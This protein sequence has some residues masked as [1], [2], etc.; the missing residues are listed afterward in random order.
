[1]IR[2]NFSYGNHSEHE[3]VIDHIRKISNTLGKY[4][5]I[6]QEISGSKV[7]IGYLETPV[8]MKEDFVFTFTANEEIKGEHIIP[9]NT[10]GLPKRVKPGEL[11]Y[12]NEGQIK[13]KVIRTSL[14]EIVCKVIKGGRITSYKT[15]NLPMSKLSLPVLTDKD[16]EDILFGINKG[17][18]MLSVSCVRNAWDIHTIKKFLEKHGG[19]NIPIIVRIENVDAVKN[20]D[21]IMKVCDGVIIVRGELCVEI[22][23]KT[24]PLVQ[25]RIIAQANLLGKPAI[26]S[27]QVLNSMMDNPV[28]IRTEVADIAN[29]VFDLADAFILSEETA[30]GK[31][32]VECVKT[33]VDIITEGEAAL[34]Y[35]VILQ[36]KAEFRKISTADALCYAI[37]QIAA[38]LDI[39]AII[40]YTIHTSM[41]YQLAKYK[42]KVPIIVLSHNQSILRNLSLC[43]GV[44]PLSIEKLGHIDEMLSKGIQ[45]AKQTGLFRSG[46]RVIVAGN[47]PVEVSEN[48]NFMKVVMV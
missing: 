31:Y 29:A 20:I 41:V 45:T 7:R 19:G 38:D 44:L 46:D 9:I 32:P 26:I 42:P 16:K 43:W 30:I 27:T 40:I 33:I 12:L 3:E 23:F 13:L 37:C 11:I 25:K 5:G 48:I 14:S 24:L 6:I 36:D 35:N 28:P 21:E 2:L 10:P 1:M 15:L 17:I 22:P 34:E 4:I 8:I 39:S 47:M 18:D